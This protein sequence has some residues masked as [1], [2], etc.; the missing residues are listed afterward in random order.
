[1]MASRLRKGAKATKKDVESS[2]KSDQLFLIALRTLGLVGFY[3]LTSIGLTFYQSSLLKKIHFPMLIVSVHFIIKFFLSYLSRLAYSLY[4]GVPRVYLGW[5]HFLGRVGFVALVAS[6]DIGLSQWSF[7]YIQ[8]ALYTVT[9]STSIIFILFFA[10]LFGLEKKHWSL[11]LIVS[12][13]GTGLSMFT[14]KSTDFNVIGFSMVLSA[15]FLS[16][17]RWTLSQSIMQRSN[18]GLSNPVDMIFHVQPVMVLTLLPFVLGFEGPKILT[19]LADTKDYDMSAFSVDIA[20]VVAGG[21]LAF[22]METSEFLLLSHTSSLTL[23][24]SGIIKE[25]ITM[26]LAVV[27]Q[28]TDISF[29]NMIGLVVCLFGISIHVLKKATE[30]ERSRRTDSYMSASMILFYKWYSDVWILEKH[31]IH[32]AEEL[33]CV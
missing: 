19:V 11:I 16:G 26:S 23:S 6:L 5:N 1:M 13:I 28:S 10:I 2:L 24:I 32:I 21:V 25:I 20:E 8:V 30:T 4:T 12:M 27:Y 14:Y 7:Q 22:L 15:S 18:L 3:F 33:Y 31:T 29:I 9:K 17:I